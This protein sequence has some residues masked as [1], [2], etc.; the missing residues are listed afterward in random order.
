[1]TVTAFKPKVYVETEDEA[2]V[3]T[4]K[5]LDF[6]KFDD[7]KP[8]TNE[9]VVAIYEEPER[10]RGGIVLTDK[11]RAESEYQGKAGLVIKLGPMAYKDD[12]WFKSDVPK[13]G[14]WVAIWPSDGRRMDIH[15]VQCRVFKDTVMAII[16]PHPESVW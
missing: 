1:M 14:D 15:G 4:L 3:R 10:T 11:R 5:G 6:E 13:V 16:I 9:V 2:A 7:Y 8:L 12:K